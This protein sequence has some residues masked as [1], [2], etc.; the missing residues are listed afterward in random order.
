LARY[1]EALKSYDRAIEFDPKNVD[2]WV[3]RGTPLEFLGRSEEALKS[4]D[5]ALELDPKNANA[6]VNR[7]A[8]LMGRY[9]E[10]RFDEEIEGRGEAYK[11]SWW[12]EALKSCDRAIELDPKSEAAWANRGGLLEDDPTRWEEAL[13]SYDRA[14]KLNPKSS[15]WTSRGR[16]LLK[17]NKYEEAL[18]SC[19]RALE[20]NPEDD[21]AKET[22]S[23]VLEAMRQSK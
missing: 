1:D 3:Y 15:S 5:R 19:N 16:L 4:Y 23:K 7:S 9:Q 17:L 18:N 10:Y 11:S 20:I 14:L 6:W 8:A 2:A 22:R 13:S 21:F 12:E